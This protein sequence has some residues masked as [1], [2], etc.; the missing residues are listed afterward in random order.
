[1]L[2]SSYFNYVYTVLVQI[3]IV[4]TSF[5]LASKNLSDYIVANN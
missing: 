2:S 3:P 4:L 5:S 1:M